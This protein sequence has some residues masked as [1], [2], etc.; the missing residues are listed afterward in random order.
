MKETPLLGNGPASELMSPETISKGWWWLG[1]KN[2][3]RRSSLVV[4]WLRP[5]TF[6]A[7][8]WVQSLVWELRSHI[9]LLHAM[10][11]KKSWGRARMRSD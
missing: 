8:A 1:S 5:D 6:N 3:A 11:K 9:K 10:T 2:G 7:A 4:Q